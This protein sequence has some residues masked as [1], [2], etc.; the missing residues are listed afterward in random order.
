MRAHGHKPL[1]QREIVA[2]RRAEDEARQRELYGDALEAVF[3]LRR[4]GFVVNRDGAHIR[5]GNKVMT[6]T[7]VKAMAARE[8]SVAGL[9]SPVKR[10]VVAASGLRVGQKV[11][12]EP[13][14]P[15]PAAP[16]AVATPK[17]VKPPSPPKV[18]PPAHSTDL[19]A[20]PR[21]VWLDLGVLKIDRRYQRE[22]SGAGTTHINRIVREF[23]WSL[24]QPIVVSERPDGTYAVIDGQHRAAA[25][26]KHPL[27]TDLPCYIIEA[28]DMATQARIFAQVNSRRLGLTSQQKFWAAHAAGEEVAVA[29]NKVCREAGVTI[30]RA[31]PSYDIPALSILSPFTLQKVFLQ[32]GRGPL[33]TA[34][35][36]LAETHPA[37]LNAFRAPTVVA[38]ARIAAGKEF[39]A[40]RM[41]QVIGAL[42]LDRLYDDARKARVSGGGTLETATERVL[43]GLYD[44]QAVAA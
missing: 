19:G 44:G 14:K 34:L 27:I 4:R 12:I 2:Q 21:V 43:R 18:A 11:V 29:V 15:K 28:P 38:L 37:K 7:E 30:L 8:S 36:L 9:A 6:S 20:K 24:Y 3:L 33:S 10:V 22:I 39:G 16:K 1:T 32:V 40:N 25:A 42:D 17:P 13:K 41:R 26:K 23:S 35:K 5:V 31:V